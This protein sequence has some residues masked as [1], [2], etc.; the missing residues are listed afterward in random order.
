MAQYAVF[1]KISEIF[2]DSS[3]KS[4]VF[5]DLHKS[6]N[7]RV[8]VSKEGN[9]MWK[10]RNFVLVAAASLIISQSADA[11]QFV[12]E[13]N[14]PLSRQEMNQSIS[15]DVVVDETLSAGADSYAIVTAADEATV[16]AFLSAHGIEAEKVSEVLF[17]NS[18]EIG[19]GTPA[20]AT[21]R[22][23]HDVYVV[24]RPIPGVGFLG[25]EKKQQIS[26]NSNAAIVKLGDIIEWDHSYLTGH[27]T[28]CVY[29][30]DSPE[31]LREHGVLAGAPV[32]KITKVVQAGQ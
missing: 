17:I 27:G 12:V 31:T 16:Q 32:G 9:N 10:I 6:L 15:Y 19:G 30:A 28:Y 7:N 21:L 1:G 14:K 13:L 20:G 2:Q 26:R 4:T 23:G 18:P 3:D 5:F 8:S 22:S 25:F 29:R 24:E 11:G